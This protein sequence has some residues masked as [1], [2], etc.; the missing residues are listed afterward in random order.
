M[1]TNKI[2]DA[3]NNALSA[4]TLCGSHKGSADLQKN[5]EN[6]HRVQVCAE[7]NK[8]AL[9]C[10]K[11][12]C[13]MRTLY[14]ATVL[15]IL[16][17]SV[18]AR[19]VYAE[20]IFSDIAGHWGKANIIKAANLGLVN[21]L[22]NGTFAPDRPISRGELIAVLSR[23]QRIEPAKT[24]EMH[25]AAGY[26]LA[27]REAGI[28]PADYGTTPEF[29]D[30]P[31]QRIEAVRLLAVLAEKNAMP[32]VAPAKSFVDTDTLSDEDMTALEIVI[33]AGIM[34]GGGGD[35][36]MPYKTT[37]R[38][39]IATIFVNID[40]QHEPAAGTGY[41]A[42]DTFGGES[43]YETFDISD[44][45]VW[46][47]LRPISSGGECFV[48]LNKSDS[49]VIATS[50]P[51][52]PEGASKIVSMSDYSEYS[53]GGKIYWVYSSA[54]PADKGLT[55]ITL[56]I[57][58]L[59][60]KT[61]GEQI[62]SNIREFEKAAD[63]IANVYRYKKG[64]KQF[65][66]HKSV[67]AAASEHSQ[68]MEKHNFF[69]HDGPNGTTLRSR[70]NSSGIN[71]TNAGENIAVGYNDPISLIA[72]W[73]NSPEHRANLVGDFEYASVAVIIEKRADSP[74]ILATQLFLSTAGKP[75]AYLS[76]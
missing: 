51:A 14:F 33:K 69:D 12:N 43:A 75:G 67:H 17:S 73:I 47:V 68:N 2:N 76:K 58:P 28:A 20:D 24:S 29:L 56:E 74:R 19:P 6:R 7:K 26:V 57:D 61:L 41:E 32:P 23:R 63:Y 8:A 42:G 4:L 18:T 54:D 25:W 38:A 65:D 52:M 9:D 59:H 30:E 64:L 37:T 27:C 66:W 44:S 49:K 11:R 1:Y 62:P 53:A 70:L 48:I 3:Q 40:L 22:P 39:E 10:P 31:I 13:H 36:F 34:Q 21:G 45:A 5:V 55:L 15:L 35:M 60:K 16:L 71:W 46:K 50:V 72:A